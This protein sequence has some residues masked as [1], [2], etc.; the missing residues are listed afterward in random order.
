[1]SKSESFSTQTLKTRHTLPTTAENPT[2]ATFSTN[3]Q[4][5]CCE[6]PT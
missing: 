6:Q 3:L 4:Q 1:M 2:T 5:L